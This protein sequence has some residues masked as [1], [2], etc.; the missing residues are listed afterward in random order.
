MRGTIP[1]DAIWETPVDLFFYR[2]PE[3]LDKAEEL[4]GMEADAAP[5]GWG[6]APS[7]ITSASEVV[8]QIQAEGYEPATPAVEYALEAPPPA[9]GGNWDSSA[10]SAPAA[11]TGW[12]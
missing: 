8:P 10:A 7:A 3:E 5:P 11:G 2:D 6:A 4:Q 1:R 12:N 9:T